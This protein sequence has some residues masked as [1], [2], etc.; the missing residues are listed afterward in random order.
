MNYE[1]LETDVLNRLVSKLDGTKYDMA[2]MPDAPNAVSAPV[3]KPKV[4]IAFAGSTFDQ[5][6]NTPKMLS[7]GPTVQQEVLNIELTFQ[8]TKRRGDAQLYA[9]MKLVRKAL[10]GWETSQSGQFY[11]INIKPFD[12]V[13][14][15]WDY[16][17]ILGAF[18]HSIADVW[19]SMDEIEAADEA[20][21][22]QITHDNTDTNEQI[23]TP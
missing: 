9:F 15:I 2:I 1:Q 4:W 16:K 17:I 3:Q 19:D 7:I 5:V 22:T 11:L 14:N 8:G 21:V 23:I 20:L 18:S 6:S 13:E 10:V 12:R